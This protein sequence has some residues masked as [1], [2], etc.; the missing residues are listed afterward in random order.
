MKLN[1]IDLNKL[2]TFLAVAEEASVSRAARR[3]A[4]TPSAVS[5]SLKLLE[6]SLELE[7]FERVGKQMRLSA[8][9]ER[10][11]VLFSEMEGRID[12]LLDEF[13][14]ERAEISGIIRVGIFLGFFRRE[15]TQQIAK[16]LSAYPRI[17]IKY[18]YAA[19]SEFEA[20]IEDGKLDV[21]FTFQ[22]PRSKAELAALPL[23]PQELVLAG[24]RK[25][26]KSANSLSE[27][28][29]LPIIDYYSQ[30]LLFAR[31]AKHHYGRE[32]QPKQV[33]AYAAAAEAVLDLISEGVGI[34]VVPYDMFRS[35]ADRG[36]LRVVAGSGKPLRDRIWMIQPAHKVQRARLQEF[37]Q[38]LKNDSVNFA[39]AG[40]IPLPALIDP[41]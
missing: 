31:W 33:R 8:K 35:R 21:A 18:V 24:E 28:E 17:Q 16:F 15:F 27:I 2:H 14:Q 6:R 20:L 22:A 10:L 29:K 41:K 40:K 9:G 12:A 26:L 32:S 19:P 37:E 39:E 34:G 23:W 36:S 1:K 5:Q 13:Y 4:L 3:L 7:L 38:F 25:L 30:P 11:K